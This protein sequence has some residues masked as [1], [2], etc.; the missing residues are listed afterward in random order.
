MVKRSVASTFT[1]IDYS[2]LQFKKAGENLLIEK[3]YSRKDAI[4]YVLCCIFLI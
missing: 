1:I 4:A 3:F 2:Y